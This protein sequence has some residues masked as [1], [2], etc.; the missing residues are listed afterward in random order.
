MQSELISMIRIKELIQERLRQSTLREKLI[1]AFSA[2]II[3]PFVTIG[4]TLS[5]LYV[6][7]NRSMILDTA[8]EN[9]RQII[10]N[11]DTSLGPLLRLSMYPVQNQTLLLMMHKDYDAAIY[12]LYERQQDYDTAG[13]I[14]KNSI[15]LYSD[16]LDSVV[17][18]QSGGGIVL[19]RS[20]DDYMNHN[21]LEQEFYRE[22]FVQSVIA[23]NGQHVLI[24]VHPDRLMSYD[25]KP[26]VSVGR[27]IVD[28]Y[29][30][31][32]L[33]LI[34]LNIGVDQLRSLWSDIRFTENTRFYLVDE[35]DRIIYSPN[36][37]E[38]G[39]S[40]AER[41]G[42]D[43]VVIK[44]ETPEA[45]Q[46]AE[47]YFIS[48]GSEISGWKAITIIPKN[49]LFGFVDTIV[50][51]ITIS[52]LV[53]LTLSIGASVYIATGITR[54]LLHLQKKMKLVSQGHL[55]V[56]IDIHQGE[57]GKIGITIDHMLGEIRR[58]IRKIYDDEEEK[59]QLELLALQSQIHPHFM[60]N[61]LNA[62]KWMAKIQGASGIEDALTAFSA[63]IRFTAK[64]ERDFVTVEEEVSFIRSYTK[65]L[66]FRYF[67]KF[68]V[69][70]D[71]EPD[72]MA[73]STLKFLLQPL[74]ENA[75]FHG[76]DGN[77]HMGRLAVRI[78]AKEGCLHML[79]EDN[80]KGLEPGQEDGIAQTAGEQ[81]NGIGVSNIRKRIGLHF[82]G[83]Y[84][85]NITSRPGG[86]RR[87]R[88]SYR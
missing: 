86:A 14:V 33:G 78:F 74:I 64:T 40:A 55:D 7:S 69:E 44:G 35:N 42:D 17:I 41:L 3:I 2:F 34:L 66:Q 81:L 16:L 20:N 49:E 37:D 5:W 59:R 36:S 72:V 4:G 13:D 76:F 32:A 67:N 18:Y 1:L 56:T 57:V 21:Y 26:V 88:S 45:T 77:T 65:I 38:I 24:G 73:C 80:G 46:N 39:H 43:F 54:P 70:L 51:T 6:D 79:V 63:V 61:T 12:P 82:G 48:F 29:T 31:E 62:I 11:I 84:G 68:D 83:E 50:R 60:Y 53:L 22:P 75:V 71:V 8:L 30:K 85:L 87:R 28:P 9:N 10:R 15:R 19:G 25:R 23:K 58:L 52:L 27:A 47:E